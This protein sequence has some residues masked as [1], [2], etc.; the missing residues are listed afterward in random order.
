VVLCGIYLAGGV[1]GMKAAGGI[2][3]TV[4]GSVDSSMVDATLEIFGEVLASAGAIPGLSVLGFAL[5]GLADAHKTAKYNKA[6]ADVMIKK[7]EQVKTSIQGMGENLIKASKSPEKQ[8]EVE[9]ILKPLTDEIEQCQKI[10]QEMCQEGFMKA[11]FKSKSNKNV[12]DNLMKNIDSHMSNLSMFAQNRQLNLQLEMD[13]KLNQ[14]QQMME[15]MANSAQ[16]KSDP[17]DMDPKVLAEIAK[18]AGLEAGK[19]MQKE[20]GNMSEKMMGKMDEIAAAVNAVGAKLD[21]MDQK[22]DVQHDSVMN[23][24]ADSSG[25]MDSHFK[26]QQDMQMRNQDLMQAGFKAQTAAQEATQQQIA[27][28]AASQTKKLDIALVMH[29][30]YV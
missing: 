8:A 29:V 4:A 26:N 28:M 15:K 9:Q 2:S 23:A 22:M 19:A 20:L 11:M 7:A 17:A 14:I 3:G 13:D 5:K 18:E 1:D 24:L 16:G 10:C 6:I 27:S 12:L 30:S 21:K 25:K